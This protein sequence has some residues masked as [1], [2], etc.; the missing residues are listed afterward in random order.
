MIFDGNMRFVDFRADF[1]PVNELQILRIRLLKSSNA[2]RTRTKVLD[3]TSRGIAR[4]KKDG[5]S[6]GRLYNCCVT[7]RQPTGSE[8]RES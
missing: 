5:G 6:T 4:V 8:G 2:S 1:H 7:N 3:A